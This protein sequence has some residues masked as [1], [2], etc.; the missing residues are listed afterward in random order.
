MFV[1]KFN[2]FNKAT[3]RTEQD[4]CVVDKVPRARIIRAVG[5][6]VESLDKLLFTDEKR[7]CSLNRQATTG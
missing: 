2:F 4:A 3:I 6:N 1:S 7:M 5:D